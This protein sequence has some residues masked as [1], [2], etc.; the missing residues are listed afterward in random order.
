MANTDSGLEDVLARLTDALSGS[1]MP[2]IPGESL[3]DLAGPPTGGASGGDETAG[4]SDTAAGAASSSGGGG[5]VLDS[6]GGAVT[7]SLESAF[8]LGSLISGLV[9]L[10]GGGSDTTQDQLTTYT[11]PESVQFEGDV[12]SGANVT[13]WGGSGGMTSGAGL[14]TGSQITVQVSAMDSQSFLDRSQDIANAV[15][16][17]MLNSNTLNDVVSDL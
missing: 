15:R 2:A 9:G 11:A 16:Q 1:E 4:L 3:A 6:V 8:G 13:D 7:Q 14:S 10:F 17:A 5:S 12:D